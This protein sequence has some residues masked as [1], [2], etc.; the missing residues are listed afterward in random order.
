MVDFRPIWMISG[1]FLIIIGIGMLFPMFMD[2]AVSNPDWEVFALISGIVLFSGG[3]LYLGNRADYDEFSV[4]QAFLLTFVSWL[5]MPAFG[6]LPFVFSEL[7]LSYTDAYFEAMS[8]ISTTGS[9]VITGLDGAPPTIP[10]LIFLTIK[11]YS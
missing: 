5:L 3:S 6:A 4:Q 2:L 11:L 1:V 10:N 9:T 8:G 7:S